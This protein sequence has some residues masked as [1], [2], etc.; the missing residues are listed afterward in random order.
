MVNHSDNS[1]GIAILTRFP[2]PP[3]S[4]LR[5]LELLEVVRRD[6][7][8]EMAEYGDLT[9]LPRPWDPATCPPGLRAAVWSWCDAVTEWIN[10]EYAWRPTQM[11]PPCW[12][13]HAHI[14]HELPALAIQRW[15]AGQ[16]TRPDA[17]EDWHR[18]TLPMFYER[19]FTR[20]G[21]STCRAGKHTDWPAESRIVAYNSAAAVEDRQTVIHLDTH[22]VTELRTAR[23]L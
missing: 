5:A 23:G 6:D 4:V 9:D 7:A 18:Y 8:D 1:S 11:I 3:G 20:L 16:S 13:H 12:P 21:E 15:D 22:P 17:L 2:T 14:A 19:M 10:H